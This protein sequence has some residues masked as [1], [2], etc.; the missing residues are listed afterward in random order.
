M[1]DEQ[2][3]RERVVV[4]EKNRTID[5]IFKVLIALGLGLFVTAV[6]AHIPLL[7]LGIHLSIIAS[8]LRWGAVR[9]NAYARPFDR[10]VEA[11]RTGVSAENTSL[12][13]AQIN[14]G[15]YQPRAGVTTWWKK[16]PKQSTVQLVDK[17][18]RILFEAEVEDEAQAIRMLH[19]LGLSASQKRAEF[20]MSS[21][22]NATQM[23]GFALGGAIAAF[24]FAWLFLASPHFSAIW[25]I[26]AVMVPFSLLSAL[27]AKLVVGVDGIHWRWLLWKRFFPMSQ[28]V[29]A[30]ADGTTRIKLELANGKEEVLYTAGSK[31]NGG[32]FQEHRD[33]VLARI[34]EA[35]RAHGELGPGADVAALVARGERTLPEWKKALLSLQENDA[36]YRHAAIRPEDLWRVVE[37]PRA[38][39]DARAGAA[40]LLR[41]GL[42]DEGKARVRVAAEAT[43]SPKLRVALEAALGESDDAADEALEALAAEKH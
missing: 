18:K 10:V 15:W 20:R 24:M 31:A 42:D 43:A 11:S 22:L 34:R 41:K 23:R 13:R 2:S 27:R 33:L 12:T 7:I 32:V 4:L 38:A 40:R 6:A 21:P 37:D 8:V 16:R 39:A 9:Q 35:K 14:D 17:R 36:G 28:I 3:F 19:A 26:F 5:G 30:R 25:P 29:R 1:T